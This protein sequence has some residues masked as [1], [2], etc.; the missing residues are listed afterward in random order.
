MLHNILSNNEVES[1]IGKR[2]LFKVLASIAGA[3]V[4]IAKT[5]LRIV[6]RRRVESALL[7]QLDASASVTRRTLVNSKIAPAG[8]PRL[9]DVHQRPFTWNGAAT[10][11]KVV[12]SKPRLTRRKRDLRFA[13][14]APSVILEN[15]VRNVVRTCLSKR[16]LIGCI[17]PFE[18][19]SGGPS[20]DS[21]EAYYSNSLRE[22][23]GTRWVRRALG[24][25]ERRRQKDSTLI[26]SKWSP[27]AWREVL[28][29]ITCF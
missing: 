11:T 3:W 6:L 16:L 10:I 27:R 8:I 29:D 4:S 5:Q 20:G 21:G 13:D 25:A 28:I 26:S 22:I 7:G 14:R 23:T 12:V 18:R 17:C 15:D 2:L 19:R 9:N 1:L 24:R